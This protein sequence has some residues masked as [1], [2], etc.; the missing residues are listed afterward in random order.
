M[1]ARPSG[2]RAE[3]AERLRARREEIEQAVMTRVY[4]IADPTSAADPTYVESLR[5]AVSTALDYGFACI[6]KG[7]ERAPPL[8]TVLLGEA[9][10]AARNG[11]SL[12]TVL[13]RYFAGYALLG[14]FLVESA[15]K[16]GLFDGT[17][18]T[19]VLRAQAALFDRLLA[20]IGEEH[21]RELQ[22]RIES[23]EQRRAERV[24]RLLAGE[25]LDTSGFAYDF[26][27]CHIGAI[28]VGPGAPEALRS[29]AATLD[30]RLLL[31]RRGHETAWA[32]F[33]ARRL[34]DFDRIA[35]LIARNWPEQISL[36]VGEPA[37]ELEGWRHTHR[38]AGA[39]L[40]IALRGSRSV[41]RYGEV[42]LLASMLQD[43]LL[44][45]SLREMYLAPLK[46]E[47][48]GGA[49]LRETLHA[50][51]EA[52]RNISSAAAALGV[53]RQTVNRHLQAIERRLGRPLGDC[54]LEV[55]A[56][57]RLEECKVSHSAST[58]VPDRRSGAAGGLGG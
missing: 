23:S 2:A 28:A 36:A 57:L 49:S 16:G 14:D 33:G 51:F 41:V 7:E 38:Q 42:A 39:A 12:D 45:T 31:I 50:Y 35:D 13:R 29:L 37:P 30:C 11:V 22:S 47:R 19:P 20:A 26:D 4:A 18:L 9:R 17:Q 48:D 44:V 53:S 46:R 52:E 21:A 5:L 56:T 1:E 43:D 3:L 25:L 15:R 40:P 34:V 32:W 55:E 27:S 58:A 10:L 24:E 8:P 54:A 6:E